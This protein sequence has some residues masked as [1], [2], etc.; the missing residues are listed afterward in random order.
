MKM[1]CT[2]RHVDRIACLGLQATFESGPCKAYRPTSP[3]G[4]PIPSQRDT[5]TLYVRLNRSS[6]S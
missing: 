2:A 3:P 1:L 6:Y 5:D 4:F